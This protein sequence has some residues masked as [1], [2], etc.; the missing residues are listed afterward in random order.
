M[1]RDLGETFTCAAC[2]STFVVPKAALEKYPGWVPKQCLG[3]RPQKSSQQV[4][5]RENRKGS[6]NRRATQT[7]TRL[8]TTAEVVERFSTG[9]QTGLFTDGGCSGNPGPGGWGVVQV[10]NGEVQDERYGHEPHTTNNRMELRAL[11][12]AFE[13]APSSTPLVVYTDSQLCV[14]SMLEWAPTWAKRNWQRK[15]GPIKNLDLV[16]PLYAL[17][18]ARPELT[19]KWIAAHSGHVWNE[20]ADALANRYRL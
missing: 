14:R 20:Y 13:M 17:V 7:K 3:C 4:N 5:E 1:T 2:A 12:E 11:I 9:P 8:L 6:R 18:C 15:G 16:Q 10:L 19:L